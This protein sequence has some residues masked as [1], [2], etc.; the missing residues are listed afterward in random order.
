[1]HTES[2]GRYL[3]HPHPH[4]PPV[5]LS[6]SHVYEKHKSHLH[7]FASHCY[8][9]VYSGSDFY[10]L[11][12]NLVL[13]PLDFRCNNRTQCAVVAGPDVFPDPCPGTYKYLEV[14]YEC[15]PYSTYRFLYFRYTSIAKVAAKR[16]YAL[17]FQLMFGTLNAV[18]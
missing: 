16:K 6:P 8:S 14:Q 18:N 7:Y 9:F 1:M 3:N 2:K 5:S 10:L 15:V 13:F 17:W 4:C 12:N 11:V